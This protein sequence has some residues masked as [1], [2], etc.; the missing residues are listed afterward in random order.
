MVRAVPRGYTVC[1]DA[2]LTPKI[3]RYLAEFTNG[4]RGGLKVCVKFSMNVRGIEDTVHKASVSPW[5]GVDVLFMQSDGGLTPMERFCG[6][7]AVLSGPA[8]GVVGYAVTSHGFMENKP[9]I[10]FDMGGEMK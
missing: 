1:V 8:G 4:F 2:Y 10:G 5:Q 3:H 9:V 7:R 6:S